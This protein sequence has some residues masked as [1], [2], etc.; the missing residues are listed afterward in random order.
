MS[1]E[2][3]SGYYVVSRRD[4]N[5]GE[6]R[7]GIKGFARDDFRHVV[8]THIASSAERVWH[9]LY[10]AIGSIGVCKSNWYRPG[11]SGL[12]HIQ[13]IQEELSEFVMKS[14]ESVF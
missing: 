13:A 4:R 9:L 7:E 10:L 1:V 2:K 6:N 3:I 8:C 5:I 14:W 12:D 11:A